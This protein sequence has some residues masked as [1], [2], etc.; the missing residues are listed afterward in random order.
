M[1]YETRSSK[2]SSYS[3][4][5]ETTNKENKTEA[6]MDFSIKILEVSMKLWA[7]PIVLF[8][9]SFWDLVNTSI[10][11][12]FGVMEESNPIA[13]KVLQLGGIPLLI[14]WKLTITSLAIF[15]LEVLWR[16]KYIPKE[17]IEYIYLTAILVYVV[18]YTV[19]V[20]MVNYT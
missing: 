9:I 5:K 20:C 19:V 16:K 17:Q 13:L 3:T 18:L 14:V 15:L 10:G 7:Y 12:H 11:L 6:D 2:T 8:A 1:V 4:K